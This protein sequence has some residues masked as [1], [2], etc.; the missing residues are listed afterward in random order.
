MPD[1]PSL[2]E[3]VE[4][5]RHKQ[6]RQEEAE[7]LARNET[8]EQAIA[9]GSIDRLP[10]VQEQIATAVSFEERERDE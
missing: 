5:L 10:S 9:D 6:R 8:Y 1:K 7:I 4:V 2:T 3:R